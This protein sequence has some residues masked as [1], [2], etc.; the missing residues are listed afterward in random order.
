MSIFCS[1]SYLLYGNWKLDNRNGFSPA[2]LLL[3]KP[4]LQHL[5]DKVMASITRWI[6]NLMLSV[7]YEQA[8]CRC[9]LYME[10][11]YEIW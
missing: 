7:I 11:C 8:A 9:R 2:F 6:E 5:K 4:V 10:D 3:K 1:S